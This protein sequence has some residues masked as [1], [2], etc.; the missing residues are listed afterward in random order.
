MHGLYFRLVLNLKLSAERCISYEVSGKGGIMKFAMSLILLVSAFSVESEAS[1]HFVIIQ[2]SEIIGHLT[3][4]KDQQGTINI[5]YFVD[6]NGRGPKIKEVLILNSE[7]YPIDW[8]IEGFSSFGAP[9]LETYSWKNGQGQWVSQADHGTSH[10]PSTPLYIANNSSPWSFGLYARALL[11]S[12]DRTLSALPPQSLLKLREIKK[13]TAGNGEIP[14]TLYAIIGTEDINLTPAIVALDDNNK[15]FAHSNGRTLLIRKGYETEQKK[16]NALLRSLEIERLQNLQRTLAHHYRYPL[17]I[18]NVRIFDSLAG[19]L[20]KL[21][22][23][24]ITDGKIATIQP[25]QI[26]DGTKKQVV[27]DGEGGTLIPGFFDMHSHTTFQSGL[28]YLAAGVTSTRDLGNQNTMLDEI[29]REID[30]GKLAGP[31][32][33]PAGL[34]EGRSQYSTNNGYVVDSLEKAL[35]AVRWYADQGYFEIKTYNSMNPDW[36]IPIVKEADR[37]GLGVSGHVPAF[38][39][40]NDLIEA[41][42]RS[43]AHI[44]QLMLGWLL[45]PGED[46]RT[47]LRVTALKR[48]AYLDL[49]S[50]DVVKTL[51]MMVARN[52]ALDPTAMIHERLLVSR[53]GVIQPG[54]IAY[55]SHM[56]VPYQRYRKL[57]LVPLLEEGDSRDYHLA[58]S[59]IMDLIRMLH[60]KG[61]K[62]LLGTD[63]GSGL[64]L[65]RELELYVKAGIPE[66]TV[67]S[68]ATLGAATY[69]NESDKLGIIEVGKL[70][71]FSMIPGNPIDN[72]SNIR[73]IRMVS[74]GGV[75]YFPQEIYQALDIIPF[76]NKPRVVSQ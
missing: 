46:T 11:K 21:K 72:I 53:P 31:R 41:G 6:T 15:L 16:L 68:M 7:G 29:R 48:A 42:Y 76:A 43:I 60:E 38:A 25:Y 5:D 65:H 37:L 26:S 2:N 3:V 45:A 19:T 17:R 50:E 36:I 44:N 57:P 61:V 10:L 58:F 39:S 24:V 73:Q 49:S 56:P 71:D 74:K 64:S 20:G 75:I 12:D 22:T 27:I 1:E 34:I 55:L 23:V 35:E 66:S 9:V 70:A 8:K 59:K 28:L 33:K 18:N 14:I 4:V 62:L 69:M 47:P 54:D 40:A 67:L 51:D 32:I 63:D 13:T 30:S 52:V